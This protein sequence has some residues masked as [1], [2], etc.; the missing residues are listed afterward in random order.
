M[1]HRFPI[2]P[3]SNTVGRMLQKCLGI[4]PA[5]EELKSVGRSRRLASNR[6]CRI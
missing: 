4:D 1:E 3:Q 2:R 6:G 5:I